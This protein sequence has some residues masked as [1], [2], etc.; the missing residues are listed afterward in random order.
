MVAV[1]VPVSPPDQ[2]S[3]RLGQRASS[4]TV[5]RLRSLSFF[6]ILAYLEPP[7]IVS[8][9]HLGFG[10]GFFFVPTSTE[11][12]SLSRR[13]VKSARDGDS[14]ARRARR[15]ASVLGFWREEEEGEGEGE[16]DVEKV[17]KGEGWEGLKD[18][19]RE[20]RRGYM[21]RSL[22]AASWRGFDLFVWW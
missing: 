14:M 6:L 1:A 5:W 21:M 11:Y 7:G 2:H 18:L 8:F 9:I 19:A 15:S 16:G 10:R 12:S 4:Q 22:A 13:R 17:L 20:R 3:P